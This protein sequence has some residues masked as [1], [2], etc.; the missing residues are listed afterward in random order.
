MKQEKIIV[1]GGGLAGS[2]AAWQAAERG[3]EVL[4]YEM[5]PGTA[6]AVHKTGDCA[7]LV[8]SNSLGTNQAEKA[9]GLLKEE[10]RKAGSLLLQIA[11]STR[12]PAGQALAV[13]R[14]K[15]AQEVTRRL[16]GHPRISLIREEIKE[17]P[18]SWCILA[19]G[20]LTSPPLAQALM[21]HC[22]T[23]LYYYD[24]VS[25]IVISESLNLSK[26]YQASR[27]DKGG[28]NAYLNAPFTKEEYDT[29]VSEIQK[30]DR[31]PYA[32]YEDPKF[33]EACMPVEELVDR[34]SET[35]R[36]G[37]MKPVGLPDPRT[38]REPYAV[39]Q[40]RAE[41]QEKTL[42]NLVGFQTRM[43]WG[44]QARVFKMIPGLEF[45]EFVRFGVMHRNVY[46]NAPV[47]LE[48]T[49][50]LRTKPNL[51]LAGQITGVEGYVEDIASGWLAGVNAVFKA[52]GEPPVV[53][54]KTTAIGALMHYITSADPEVF[55]PINVNFSLFPSLSQPVK[56]K[57]LRNQE[58]VA[59]ARSDVDKFLAN[60]NDI[61][62]I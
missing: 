62:M 6:T 20:P 23:Y 45:A 13:D 17:I 21:K 42:Y 38:C 29:F 57:S 11:D 58:I 37:P 59:R 8:C 60:L 28:D 31:V 27:Y 35:L 3:V 18:S 24:A 2:E 15:F 26:L 32:P 48:P 39:V 4:L 52:R 53:F 40:L 33:F 47:L 44:E 1:I 19:T 56:N 46:V 34:G 14:V 9:P 51:F 43:K 30:S 22:G 50:E 7:E 5:R 54:P 10:L 55:G 61:R 12:V 16:L 36:F 49:L 41:N 25:P